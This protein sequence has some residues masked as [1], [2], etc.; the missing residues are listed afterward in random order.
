MNTVAKGDELEVK[1]F[2]YLNDQQASGLDVYDL[3]APDKCKIYLKKKYF[4]SE[5]GG[6][7]TFDVVVEVFRQGRDKPSHF[8]VFECKNHGGSLKENLV[9]E[10]SDK[11]TRIFRHNV[12]GVIVTASRLQKGAENIALSRGLGIV[13]YCEDGFEFVAERK[14]N[15]VFEK[16]YVASQ[17][18]ET[19]D[20]TK[21]LRF[22]AFSDGAYFGSLWDLFDSFDSNFTGTSKTEIRS[23]APSVPYVSPETIES[24]VDEILQECHYEGGPVELEKIC[25]RLSVKLSFNGVTVRDAN[26]NQVLGRANFDTKSITVNF[27]DDKGRER[28]TLAHEIGHFV[29]AHGRYL[30]S[31]DILE[32]DLLI[33]IESRT[34]FNYERL[35]LQANL[36]AAALLLPTKFFLKDV[37]KL[38]V[39]LGL[40]NNLRDRQRPYIFVDD[41]PCNF[42]PYN[43]LLVVLSTIFEVSKTAVEIKLKRLDL[44]TDQRKPNAASLPVFAIGNVISN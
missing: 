41:Q 36:F 10:F 4:D 24:L 26:G 13:K 7:V 21:Q 29:L 37:E 1:F 2:Q 32:R 27:H 8:A 28:F 19:I 40:G 14:A 25:D 44:L 12:K 5:R 20:T 38:V 39:R 23:P 17:L 11:L 15:P 16:R 33:G 6:Y 43:Q 42:E 9:T 35:E 3:Y 31:E 34:E 30:R 18:F 22:S